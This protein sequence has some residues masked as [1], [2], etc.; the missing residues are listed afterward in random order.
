MH[1]VE[2]I[3]QYL[4]ELEDEAGPGRGLSGHD[5]AAQPGVAW[6]LPE[7]YSRNSKSSLSNGSGGQ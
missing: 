3:V 2:H 7:V 1:V 4:V 6:V 5:T